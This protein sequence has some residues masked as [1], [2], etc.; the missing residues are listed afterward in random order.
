MIRNLHKQVIEG[1]LRP[2]GTFATYRM[3]PSDTLR[4]PNKGDWEPNRFRKREKHITKHS[5][6]YTRMEVFDLTT[7]AAICKGPSRSLRKQLQVGGEFPLYPSRSAVV[8]HQRRAHALNFIH[9]G[10]SLMDEIIDDRFFKRTLQSMID[11]LPE[12]FGRDG[13]TTTTSSRLVKN[14]YFFKRTRGRDQSHGLQ[15]RR[16]ALIEPRTV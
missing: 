5:A 8:V 4:A 12:V 7:R 15:P 14:L 3:P 11:I 6:V 13:F 9:Q 10:I 2:D 16:E 1:P